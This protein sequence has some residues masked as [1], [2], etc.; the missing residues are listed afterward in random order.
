MYT[1]SSYLQPE[2]PQ[3]TLLA[4]VLVVANTISDDRLLAEICVQEV[5]L[6]ALQRKSVQV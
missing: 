4:I 2:K 6:V 3:S 1:S 5:E